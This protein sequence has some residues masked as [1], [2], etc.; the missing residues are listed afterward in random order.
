RARVTLENDKALLSQILQLD[1]ATPFEV[2]HPSIENSFDITAVSL[3]S[4]YA[5]ALR[6]REDLHRAEYMAEANLSRYKASF[7]GY[8]P[9]VNVF[10]SYGSQYNSFLEANPQYG[11]FGNQFAVIFPN[12]AYGVNVQIPLFD[13]MVTRNNRVLNKVAY[14]N[15]LLLKDNVA[16]TIKIDVRRAY[17][18]YVAARQAYDASLVQFTAGELALRTQQESFVLGVASQVELAQANQTYVT[19][20][21]SKAQAEVTLIFQQMMMEYALGTLRPETL[22][23]Q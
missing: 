17:N 6:H 3:D 10:A 21:A 22:G 7:S 18:N 13:R 16:K 1:P 11:K 12:I 4:L 9:T 20:A 19:A 15:A 14:E 8:L 5:I 23:G 2:E